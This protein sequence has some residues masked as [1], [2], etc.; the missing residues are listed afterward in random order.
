MTQM[1]SISSGTITETVNAFLRVDSAK[2]PSRR[3]ERSW[4]LCFNYFQ[5]NPHPTQNMETSCLQLGYYLASWGMLRGSSF[6]FRETNALHY[7]A[8]IEAIEHHNQTMRGFDV[9]KYDSA[10][11]LEDFDAAWYALKEAL[12]PEGGAPATL[13]SKVMMGVWGCLPSYDTYFIRTMTDLAGERKIRSLRGVSHESLRFLHA[14]WR[15]HKDEVEEVRHANP[16]WAFETGSPG[17]RPMTRAKVL[18]IF[19]FKYSW[20]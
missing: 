9:D 10:S 5:D 15:D 16:P 6:H 13:I 1:T 19:G 17:E 2:A 18:D 3:R 14:I 8:A 12:L 7:R 4:D 11:A 20:G